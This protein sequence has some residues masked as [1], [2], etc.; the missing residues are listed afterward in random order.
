MNLKIDMVCLFGH[1]VAN[2]IAILRKRKYVNF[3]NE[4]L[5]FEHGYLI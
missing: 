5:A 4:L 2:L 3:L 1:I